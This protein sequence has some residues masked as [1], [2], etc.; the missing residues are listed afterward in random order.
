ASARI[1]PPSFPRV[2]IMNKSQSPPEKSGEGVSRQSEPAYR[3]LVE[4]SHDLIWSVDAKG[5]WTF[6]NA[7]ARRIYGY[8]PSEM[9]GRPFIDFETPEQAAI[10]LDVFAR[11]KA[12]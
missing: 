10:D 7:A 3:D 8:E 9:L 12:G 6:V 2:W 5:R 4:T 11:T 1:S